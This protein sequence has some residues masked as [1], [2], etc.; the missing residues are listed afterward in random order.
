MLR[1]RTNM[2]KSRRSKKLSRKSNRK[3]KSLRKSQRR[4]RRRFGAQNSNDDVLK[5]WNEGKLIISHAWVGEDGDDAEWYAKNNFHAS[6]IQ[7]TKLPINSYCQSA[8]HLWISPTDVQILLGW[9]DDIGRAGYGGDIHY[10]SLVFDNLGE[11]LAD[12]FSDK[13]IGQKGNPFDASSVEKVL[14]DIQLKTKNDKY[15]YNEVVVRFQGG[16][17]ARACVYVQSSDWY[18]MNTYKQAEDMKKKLNIQE[19]IL[20]I[21]KESGKID[22]NWNVEKVEAMRRSPSPDLLANYKEY[23]PSDDE[24]EDETLLWQYEALKREIEELE[25]KLGGTSAG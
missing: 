16:I 9:H 19:P 22:T 23:F 2:P 6:I 13:Y 14:E 12:K 25:K 10:N 18:T 20:V 24:D 15:T 5:M 1:Y 11:A 4:F 17:K 8:P 3:S 21:D 7:N